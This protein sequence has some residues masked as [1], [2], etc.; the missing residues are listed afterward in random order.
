M[1]TQSHR[2][3]SIL[4]GSLWL[5]TIFHSSSQSW[6]QWLGPHRDGHA[7]DFKAPSSWPKE[8]TRQWTVEVG[9]G[10]ATPALAEGSLY[11]FSRQE[12]REIVRCMDADS[13]KER[14]R[15]EYESLGATGP[16]SRFSGPRSSPALLDGKLVTLGVR[17]VIS[18]LDA[19]TGK[20]LWRK[21]DFAGAWPRF[22]SSSSPILVD[23][24][25][26]AQVGGGD[27]GGV[28]AYDLA[29]GETKWSWTGDGP[30]YASL[31]L[32]SLDVARL[33]IAQ[34]EGKMVALQATDGKSVWET[35]FAP[36]RRG[37]NAATPVVQGDTL[38][39]AGSGRGTT[40]VKFEKSGD[41]FKT[42]EL[43][44]NSDHSPQFNTPI[45]HDGKLFGL[46]A[47]NEYFCVDAKTG[48]TAWSFNPA[49]ENAEG[50]RRRGGGYGS[51][52]SAGKVLLTLTPESR[53]TVLDPSADKYVALAQ[54]T[55][56]ENQTYAYPV[57][58]GNRIYI[59][60]QDAVT[61]WRLE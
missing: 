33:V 56:S 13:G 23:G 43:W 54:Y 36:E 59:K 9:E 48:Q 21:D 45:L 22:F 5:L 57:A 1:K 55:V 35:E 58:T 3:L 25:C 30:A 18:C 31:S 51:I 8:L 34:T 40:A 15:H 42:T 10:V 32:L 24:M 4:T 41:G 49:G 20:L 19:A 14:W 53:L 61:L 26:L 50:G 38:Y 11:V 6:P 47:G 28:V 7:A 17:G 29:S 27:K 12:G 52:V 46:S 44:K 60:D 2:F 37:Y 16:A 39:Y